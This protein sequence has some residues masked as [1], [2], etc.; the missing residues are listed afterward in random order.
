MQIADIAQLD[1][2]ALGAALALTVEQLPE[3]DPTRLASIRDRLPLAAKAT[4]A[5]QGKTANRWAQLI[6]IAILGGSGLALAWWGIEALLQPQ[7]TPSAV[8]TITEQ[9]S[10]PV[11]R[12]APVQQQDQQ[13]NDIQQ[14]DE[15]S[16]PIIFKQ[17]RY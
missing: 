5:T 15:R 17:E 12:Q 6:L 14:Q 13:T 10:A 16:G 1:D 9:Q 11:N 2:D 3:A 7:P 8:P 4:S